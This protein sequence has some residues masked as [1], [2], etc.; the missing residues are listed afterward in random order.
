QTRRQGID[1]QLNA[2]P[3]AGLGLWASTAIQRSKILQ[4][5]ASSP[6]SLG[7]QIDHVPQLLYAAGS[8]Y[9]ASEALRLSAWLNGQTSYYLERTNATGKFGGYTHVNLSAAYRLSPALSVELMVRNLFDRYSE[10]V[11]WD[12]AQSLHAPGT[13]RS[14]YG[15]LAMKF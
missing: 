1:L 12:G 15:T 2:R 10:Y 5:D 3:T 9:Q 7:K 8:D 4:A 11:W 14:V 6:A 13:P